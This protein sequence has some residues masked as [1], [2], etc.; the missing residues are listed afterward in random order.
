MDVRQLGRTGIKATVLS[1][2]C[3]AVGGLMTKGAPADQERAVQRAL[4]MGITYFDTAAQYGMGTSETNLGRILAKL[5]PKITVATKVRLQETEYGNIGA[6]IRASLAASLARLGLPSVDILYLHNRILAKTAGDGL[7]VEA[8]LGEVLP[9]FQALKA[10]G[11]IR[12]LGVTA[13]GETAALHRVVASGAFDVAQICYNALNPSAESAGGGLPAHYPGQD[14]AGLM[15][16]ANKAGM[17]TVGIR[18]LAGGAL[19]GSETRHPL[20]MQA[21]E[22]IGSGADFRADVLNAR[23]FEPL[24]ADGTVKSLPELA[25]RFA[26]ASPSLSTTLVGLSTL[27]ELETAYAACRAGP[28]PAKALAKLSEIRKTIAA[29]G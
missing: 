6:G 19:S 25:M 23:R 28:L 9:A 15:T 5:R 24:L 26:I 16:A 3:G 8:V 10:E 18:V 22:P 21:V 20:S 4:D 17:G 1:Y 2:G 27:D 11:K 14:Y 12:H 13:L 7:S 29:A